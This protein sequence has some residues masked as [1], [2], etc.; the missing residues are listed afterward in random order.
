MNFFYGF[1]VT[2]DPMASSNIGHLL[3]QSQ[4][5]PRYCTTIIV[6][7]SK[8]YCTESYFA[9]KMKF[10]L[11]LIYCFWQRR[12][13]TKT[14]EANLSLLTRNAAGLPLQTLRGSAT[15]SPQIGKFLNDF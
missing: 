2:E 5:E 8:W 13:E 4:S 12:Q 15:R 6:N 9:L 11:K 7:V 1:H 14:L 3:D 10:R